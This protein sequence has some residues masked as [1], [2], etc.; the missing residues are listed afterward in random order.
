MREA[1]S[2][3]DSTSQG[4]RGVLGTVNSDR[5]TEWRHWVSGVIMPGPP[6]SLSVSY[7]L[8][9][10]EPGAEMGVKESVVRRQRPN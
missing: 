2:Q 1:V 9:C 7:V 6:F 5:H 3:E 10:V 4:R 8:Q